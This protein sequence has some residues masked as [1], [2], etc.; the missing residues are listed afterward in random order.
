M[1]YLGTKES[2][3]A[4]QASVEPMRAE[5]GTAT[6]ANAAASG[7]LMQ[8]RTKLRSAHAGSEVTRRNE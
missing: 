3:R 5:G 2:A 6:P 8:K 4:D 7:Q 1:S